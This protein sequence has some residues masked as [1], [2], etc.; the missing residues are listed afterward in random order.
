[1]RRSL[2]SEPANGCVSRLREKGDCVFM[3]AV[4]DAVRGA[5]DKAT[6]RKGPRGRISLSDGSHL[7][8]IWLTPHAREQCVERGTDEAGIREAILTGN[9]E[10]AKRGR[11][12]Y[13]VNLQ[14][15]GMWNGERYRIKQVAPVVVEKG[16]EIVVVTVYT[17]YF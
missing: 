2:V 11:F 14:F 10:A 7:K 12:M 9:R 17:F 15:D 16:D 3:L 8:R 4:E 5:S 13:R 6:R 1:M